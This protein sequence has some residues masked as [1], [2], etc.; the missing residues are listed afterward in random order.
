MVVCLIPDIAR[1][2][3]RSVGKKTDSIVALIQIGG[4]SL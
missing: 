3:F 1:V 4:E 2:L